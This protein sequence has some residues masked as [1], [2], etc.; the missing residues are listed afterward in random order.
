MQ[1]YKFI[2]IKGK[3]GST[4]GYFVPRLYKLEPGLWLLRNFNLQYVKDLLA[5][6]TVWY[7]V[8]ENEF[9]QAI[10]TLSELKKTRIFDYMVSR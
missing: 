4:T 1:P 3:E 8:N 7:T 10:K 5:G 2:K 9:D 6:W